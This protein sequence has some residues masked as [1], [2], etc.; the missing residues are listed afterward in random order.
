[1]KET[2]YF[3]HDYNSQFDEKILKLRMNHWWEWYWIYWAIIERLASNKWKLDLD[4]I[5]SIAFDMRVDKNIMTELLNNYDLFIIDENEWIFY[6]YRLLTHFEK[7][8]EIKD[9]KSKAGKKWMANRWWPNKQKNNSVITEDNIVITKHN[10]VKKNKVKESKEDI[11]N[12]IDPIATEVATIN[13]N[14]N[15]LDNINKDHILKKYEINEDELS[16]EIVLFIDYWKA[17]IINWKK[18]DIWKQRWNVQTTFEP[19]KRFA[20]WLWNNKKWNKRNLINKPTW[21]WVIE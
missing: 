14:S 11:V 10:K 18:K 6:N 17:I 4:K 16:D 9:R 19:N 3:S 7:R 12:Y 1:M 20:T 8:D 2:F 15:F 21:I 13:N 5:E